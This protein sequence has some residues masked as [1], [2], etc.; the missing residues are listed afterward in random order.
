MGSRRHGGYVVSRDVVIAGDE[1]QS[2]G[3]G[4]GDQKTVERVTVVHRQFTR[5][6]SM[7][8]GQ[9]QGE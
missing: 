8:E 2:L 9:R 4:L 5:L 3:L 6:L 7:M 1:Y